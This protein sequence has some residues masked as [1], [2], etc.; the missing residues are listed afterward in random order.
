ML[1]VLVCFSSNLS[2]SGPAF[3]F[4]RLCLFCAKPCS[5]IPDE[6]HPDRW[7]K[8]PEILCKT[9]DRK[10]QGQRVLSFKEVLLQVNL[11]KSSTAILKVIDAPTRQL[12]TPPTPAPPS[13]YLF[14]EKNWAKHFFNLENNLNIVKLLLMIFFVKI[15]LRNNLNV[16]YLSL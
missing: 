4:R 16:T 3:D 7:E 15:F 12:I 1:S 5:I 2:A 9:G 14:S 13:I 11:L 8:N 10:V 6:W